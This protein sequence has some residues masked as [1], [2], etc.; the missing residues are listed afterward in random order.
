MQT[1]LRREYSFELFVYTEML[2]FHVFFLYLYFW[3]L[4]LSRSRYRSF[5]LC[6]CLFLDEKRLTWNTF[7]EAI[8]GSFPPWG[9]T[10]RALGLG[11]A[12]NWIIFYIFI[13]YKCTIARGQCV[14]AIS[15]YVRS[16]CLYVKR[17]KLV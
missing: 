5:A 2:F 3:F 14:C 6:A 12:Q 16:E 4:Y 15:V 1:E 9:H 7:R 10:V 8:G 11:P 17:G 13:L